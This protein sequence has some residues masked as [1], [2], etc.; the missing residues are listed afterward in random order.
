MI[1][2]LTDIVLSLTGIVVLAPI[3][4]LICAVIKVYDG[5]PVF[6][7]Q[8]RVG[9]DG[10]LFTLFK[11][12]KFRSDEGRDGLG[13]TLTGDDRMTKPGRFLEQTKLDELPQLFN[14]LHGKMSFV[15]P[16]PESEQYK[17]LVLER[18]SG[19]LAF[20]PGIFGPNQIKF[21]NEPDLYPEDADPEVFYRE[22]MF[23]VKAK[24]DLAYF[25][26]ATIFSDLM[27]IVSGVWV[28]IFGAK[29]LDDPFDQ[30]TDKYS[31]G[32]SGE[33]VTVYSAK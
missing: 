22:V 4:L 20:S 26:E 31:A 14:I 32:A 29:K 23:P 2:R 25:P 30:S 27:L 7:S 15:G 33:S 17:D 5:G 21:R 28:T 1:K 8:R 16:R 6:F 9:K 24:N 11:F 3:F 12:R 19:I 10:E 13:L 18:F